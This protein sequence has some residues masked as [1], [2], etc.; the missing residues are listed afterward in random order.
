MVDAR[1]DARIRRGTGVLVGNNI[2]NTT[3]NRQTRTGSAARGRSV[4]YHVSVQNDGA[5]TERLR[6]RGMGSTRRFRV[7][8]Y[9][10]AGQN[11]TRQVTGGTARTRLLAPGRTYGVRAVVTVTRAAPRH[12]SLVR[13]LTARSTTHPTIRDTVD[14]VTRRARVG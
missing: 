2:Y 6:L 8:Y 5:A 7:R 13:S 14:F 9:N 3:G 4:T 10:P 12:S 1:P 11:I